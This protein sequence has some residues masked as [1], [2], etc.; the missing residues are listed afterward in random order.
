MDFSERQ[1]QS[2]IE[3]AEFA[4]W[5]PTPEELC[6]LLAQQ[7]CPSGEVAKVFM[8]ELGSDGIFRT[9]ASFGYSTESSIEQYEVG[10]DK[11]VPMPDAYLRGE[12]I[13]YNKAEFMQAY[14]DFKTKD[15]HSPWEA[16]ALVPT[17]GKR[18]VFVF[19]LQKAL[20]NLTNAKYYFRTVAAILSL[21]QTKENGRYAEK[22]GKTQEIE[23]ENLVRPRSELRGRALTERQGVILGYIKEGLTNP[24]IADLLKYSESLIRQETVIIYSKLGVSGRR[25]LLGRTAGLLATAIALPIL[26]GMVDTILFME[27]V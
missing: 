8:G 10:L 19:R 6:R 27:S 11:S 17:I 1:I 16:A 4:Y 26:H 22:R 12:V 14:P 25:E 3:I 13:V 20:L 18:F 21:Y 2:L 23:S 5:G 7:I 15:P 9:V 24:Q